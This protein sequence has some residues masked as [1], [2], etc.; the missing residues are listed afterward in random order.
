MMT[1]TEKRL[2]DYMG[3]QVWKCRDEYGEIYYML[4]DQEGNDAINV[5]TTLEAL[6][7]DVREVWA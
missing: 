4:C 1:P 2:K 7:K 6:K 3:Y 5:Y